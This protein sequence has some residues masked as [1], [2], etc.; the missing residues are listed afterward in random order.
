MIMSWRSRCRE[1]RL[2]WPAP[3]ILTADLKS[4]VLTE[5]G[6]GKI[7][8]NMIALHLCSGQD[9]LSFL[10]DAV[11]IQSE[12]VQVAAAAQIHGVLQRLGD[13]ISQRVIIEIE[14][15]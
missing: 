5:M 9:A 1:H 7:Q 15:H 4:V 3:L 8:S 11:V 6:R 13:S 2:V 10:S 14:H 12:R